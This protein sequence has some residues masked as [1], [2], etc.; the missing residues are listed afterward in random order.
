MGMRNF[1]DRPGFAQRDSPRPP[2]PGLPTGHRTFRGRSARG[3][4]QTYDAG[5]SAGAVRPTACIRPSG[6]A[7][8][9]HPAYRRPFSSAPTQVART[10]TS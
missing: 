3:G 6:T 9:S 5:D 10:P 2:M 7:L 4:A 1:L 8:A